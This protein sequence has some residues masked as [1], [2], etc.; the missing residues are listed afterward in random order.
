VVEK[1]ARRVIAWDVPSGLIPAT[2]PNDAPRGPV[3]AITDECA[4]S[5]GDIVTGAIRLLRLGPVVGARTD[6]RCRREPRS[7]WP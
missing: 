3:V 6:C 4:G 1:L 5:D 2:Y 7:V